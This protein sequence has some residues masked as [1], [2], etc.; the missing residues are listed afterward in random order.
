MGDAACHDAHQDEYAKFVANT[1]LASISILLP[2]RGLFLPIVVM[3]LPLRVCGVVVFVVLFISLATSVPIPCA[4]KEATV[5]QIGLLDFAQSG[6][7]GN[8]DGDAF[9]DGTYS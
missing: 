4:P 2:Q 3:A 8:I 6:V 1:H 5:S 9:T 7:A